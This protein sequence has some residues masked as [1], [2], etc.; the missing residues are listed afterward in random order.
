MLVL[1]LLL[2]FGIASWNAYAAGRIWDEAEGYM[3]LVA[4]AALV[5]SVFGF[6]Q[7]AVAVGSWF[8]LSA[9]WIDPP[10][11]DAVS[12]LTYLLSI[13]PVLGACIVITIHSW[14]VAYKRRTFGSMAV[15]G[16]NTLATASNAYGALDGN[17]EAALET[18]EGFF[19]GDDD[20][21]S[22]PWARLAML[23]LLAVATAIA[24]GFTYIFFQ[25]GR[26]AALPSPQQMAVQQQRQAA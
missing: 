24:V 22:S 18:V 11:A 15:A 7:V 10:E 16:W 1:V 9:Q 3:R 5:L 14:I 13:V 21:N 26:R 12:A 6:L 20:N 23:L 25:K 8:A 4:W 17:V 19:T 2:N